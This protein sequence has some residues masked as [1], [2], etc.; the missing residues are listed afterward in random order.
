MHM[1]LTR[2]SAAMGANR[3]SNLARKDRYLA[4]LKQDAPSS[5]GSGRTVRDS[6]DRAD[7]GFSQKGLE[8][9]EDLLPLDVD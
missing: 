4:P 8:L 7:G 3:G 5:A 6:V 2:R 1:S 9:G